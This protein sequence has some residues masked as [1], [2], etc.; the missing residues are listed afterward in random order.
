MVIQFKG[1]TPGDE[2][3]AGVVASFMLASTQGETEAA[4]ARLTEKSREGGEIHE[5]PM[6]ET[7]VTFGEVAREDELHI[8]PTITADGD[9]EGAM[10]FV[11]VEEAGE[12]RIDM[13]ATMARAMGID[14]EEMLEQMAE[15]MG[16]V[17]EGVADSMAEGFEAMGEAMGEAMSG[18]TKTVEDT[19]A[20]IDEGMVTEEIVFGDEVE[21]PEVSEAPEVAGRTWTLPEDAFPPEE[22]VSVAAAAAT[23]L[24]TEF[25]PDLEQ[26]DT[27][28]WGDDDTQTVTTRYGTE[29][30]GYAVLQSQVRQE[31]FASVTF[32]AAAYGLPGDRQL[33]V[34]WSKS[35]VPDLEPQINVSV[36][37]RAPRSS[38]D[39]LGGMLSEDGEVLSVTDF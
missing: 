10:D 19:V 3:A 30:Q 26:L 17:M 2:G 24:D 1:A 25:E 6:E 15:G 16:Q 20:S 9:D 27:E 28:Q 29:E 18:M 34:T 39:A 32:T 11:V 33:S 7:V 31:S 35:Q 12:L 5:D 38:L 13:N 37:M 22:I 36:M 21:A 14:P 23:F 8:V 4:L